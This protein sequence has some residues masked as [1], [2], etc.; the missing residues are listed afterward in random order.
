MSQTPIGQCEQSLK[1][2]LLTSKLS[3]AAGGLAVSVPGL[4]HSI[5]QLPGVDMHVMGTLD[6]DNPDSAKSW[7]PRVFAFPVKG[8]QAGQYAPK[9]TQA[10]AEL[11]PDLVDV[12]GLWTYPSLVSLR[13]ARRTGSPYMITPRGMLDPWARRN[14][15]WKKHIAWIAFE[16]AHLKEA[17][18]LR[19]T[20]EMEAQHFRDMGLTNP[21]AIV[22]NGIDLPDLALR[23]DSALRSIL[24]LSRIHRKKGVRYLLTAWYALHADF[25]DWEVVIAGIDEK[26]HEAE[27][28]QLVAKLSLP[29]VRFVGEVHGDAKQLLYRDADLFVL[30]THAEN[31]GLVVV[32]ALAQETPVI[33]TTNAPWAGLTDHGCGWWIDLDQNQLTNTLRTALSQPTEKLAEMGKRGRIWVSQAFSLEQVALKM[34]DVHNW[35]AGRG[36]KPESVYD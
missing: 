24:F 8:P 33:T 9:M 3:P 22:P 13:H 34:R 1:V 26:G 11:A 36:S 19:A 35:V 16:F 29:R 5:D 10:I 4:A 25:P 31:F 32:E 30:P 27:L 12:Q 2:L 14:S 21:I 23:T 20:A 6:P 28:R 7:G 18:A 15:A 17:R